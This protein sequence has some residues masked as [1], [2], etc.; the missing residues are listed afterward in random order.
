MDIENQGLGIPEPDSLR[1][2]VLAYT[3]FK[4]YH[5]LHEAADNRALRGRLIGNVGTNTLDQHIEHIAG[6][7]DDALEEAVDA[8]R[9]ATIELGQ[10]SISL[11]SGQAL[12]LE[13]PVLRSGSGRI[14][15]DYDVEWLSSNPFVAKV[16]A[17]GEVTGG[18]SGEAVI[19][20]RGH[21]RD[22]FIFDPEDFPPGARVYTS[23]FPVPES[24][25]QAGTITTQSTTITFSHVVVPTYVT[26]EVV[27]TV[28]KSTT[29]D[30]DGQSTP[31]TETPTTPGAGEPFARNPAEEFDLAEF[32]GDKI[33][34]YNLATKARDPARDF[35]T[36]APAGNADPQDVWSDGATMWVADYSDAKLYAYNLA[37]KGRDPAKDFNTLADTGNTTAVGNWSDGTTMWV[38]DKGDRRLY[39]YNMPPRSSGALGDSRA[40]Q[41]PLAISSNLW[42]TCVLTADGLTTCW[43]DNREGQTAP[44]KGVTFTA[45]ATGG[46][47]SCGLLRDG[48]AICWGK[49]DYGQATPPDG[50]AFASITAGVQHTCALRADGMPI[51]WG[52]NTDRHG[53]LVGQATPPEGEKFVSIAAGGDHTCGLRA[54]GTVKCWGSFGAS[55]PPN[56]NDISSLND[57]SYWNSCGLRTDGT[58]ICWGH[59]NWGQASP[60]AKVSFTSITSGDVHTCGLQSTGVIICWG[61]NTKWSGSP[62]YGQATPPEGEV[63]AA[64]SAGY[65]HTCGITTDA[66]VVCWGDN[67]FGQSTPPSD[68]KGSSSAAAPPDSQNEPLNDDRV[69]ING[70][71]LNGSRI[72]SANPSLTV[73]PDQS[74]SG[75]VNLTA[76][77]GHGSHAIF[78]VGATVTWGDHQSSYWSLPISPP[79]FGSSRGDV[80]INLTAPSTPG[81]YAI[82]FA[83]Q[84]E[85]SLGHVMSATHWASGGP[86]WDN[87]D[88]IAGWDA[89]QIDFAIANGYARAPQYGWKDPISHFGASAIKIIVRP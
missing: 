11:M 65:N 23:S 53:N 46:Y 37:T 49:D 72:D 31:S 44:P 75:M 10:S 89:S 86:R 33:Y 63:F 76:A 58:A 83:A 69:F 88:D 3:K 14:L 62:H 13:Q 20:V 2:E 39:A 30:S 28:E 67:S 55:R 70:G 48:T 68:L 42:H 85:T 21:V 36:L 87:G 41:T 9:L 7:R 45:I 56:I 78:P 17:S 57:H 84:A 38:A 60:P 25:Q 32:D 73:P 74:I 71:T 15:T 24:H 79:A 12:Q 18:I 52:K 81:T 8:V 66:R 77:N 5:Y 51:C 27:V 50:E 47:H 6:E 59:N 16:S 82:I 64:V 40:G 29:T 22:E 19:S 54:N 1:L 34:A 61:S 4:F 26:G 80:A 35:N 43:G